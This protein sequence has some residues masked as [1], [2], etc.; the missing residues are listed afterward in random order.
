MNYEAFV[1]NEGKIL[2]PLPRITSVTKF[3]EYKL[4]KQN[5]NFNLTFSFRLQN[6]LTRNFTLGPSLYLCSEPRY[7]FGSTHK[8]VKPAQQRNTHC[9]LP[10][11]FGS[12]EERGGMKMCLFCL[13]VLFSLPTDS[14]C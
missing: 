6:N 3:L 8:S 7:V 1:K 10:W 5:I 9:C 4:R 13:A 14:N 11:T 2:L 12:I